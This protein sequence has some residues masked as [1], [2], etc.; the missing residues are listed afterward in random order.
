MEIFEDGKNVEKLVHRI[1][2]LAGISNRSKK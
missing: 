2:D 1:E